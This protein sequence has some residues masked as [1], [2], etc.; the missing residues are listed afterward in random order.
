MSLAKEYYSEEEFYLQKIWV[1]HNLR[2]FLAGK[3]L[4]QFPFLNKWELLVKS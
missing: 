4:S 2:E 1:N 3:E